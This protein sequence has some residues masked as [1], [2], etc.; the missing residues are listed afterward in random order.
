[1]S[2]YVMTM[3]GS[4][5]KDLGIN[6][7][8]SISSVLSEVI[9]NSYD[10]DASK[11]LIWLHPDKN[12]IIIQ[13]NGLGM[14]EK[15][16][17]DRFLSVGLSKRSKGNDNRTPKYNRSIMGRKGIGK[18]APLAIS[19]SL[20]ILSYKE[21]VLAGCKIEKD[22]LLE[23]KG[24]EPYKPL[25]IDGKTIVGKNWIVQEG[26]GT[27]LILNGV[28]KSIK[29]NAISVRK[30]IAKNFP[31]LDKDFSIYIDEEQISYKDLNYFSNLEYMIDISSTKENLSKSNNLVQGVSVFDDQ[32]RFKRKAGNKVKVNFSGYSEEF[33]VNGWIGCINDLK[34][35]KVE[36]TEELGYTTDNRISIFA[37]GKLGEYN[38]LPLVKTNQGHDAYLIGEIYADFLED[39]NYDD[40]AISSREGYIKSDPRYVS[41]IEYVKNVVS[42]LIGIRAKDKRM[43]KSEDIKRKTRELKENEI[44][45]YRSVESLTKVLPV[46]SK[47][48]LVRKASL[49][50]NTIVPKEVM[51]GLDSVLISHRYSS[52]DHSDFVLSIL[53]I[54]GVPN[55]KIIYTSSKNDDHSIPYG[56]NIYD[57]LRD[58]FRKDV[59]ICFVI[60]NDFKQS[61]PCVSE[62]GAAWVT[63]K[64]YGL[65]LFDDVK[66]SDG[67]K[68]KPLD[69][70]KVS[71]NL[72]YLVSE[73]SRRDIKSL[74]NIMMKRF[75]LREPKNFSNRVEDAIKDYYRTIREK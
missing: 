72:N 13:D 5:L 26:S 70:S 28:T 6:L 40:I 24:K 16:I 46:K 53:Q 7:Y 32:G 63:S 71:I 43:Q 10:A 56:E 37:R 64:E 47:E 48:E 12:Q 49:I 36:N 55:D 45:F 31:L 22:K 41:L 73:E 27:M 57:Y 39:T 23:N 17:N 58:E 20:D 51:Y 1:M 59:F 21:G 34:K 44:D 61:F 19:Q 30:M 50:S 52:K 67:Y 25:E 66:F 33:T 69:F 75:G 38:I 62:A 29:R 4:I 42:Q 74:K 2:K 15:E 54:I 18:L 8:S 68:Y 11:V 3:H 60:G 14:S 35:L 65:F 9:A